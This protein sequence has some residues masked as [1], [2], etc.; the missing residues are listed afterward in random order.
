VAKHSNPDDVIDREKSG[1]TSSGAPSSSFGRREFVKLIGTGS[2]VVGASVLGTE[3]IL[4][5]PQPKTQEPPDA[6]TTSLV[7]PGPVKMTLQ[8]N[9]KPHV[10]VAEPRTTLLDVLRDYIHYTGAKKVCDRGVCGACTV[11][12]NR[13]AMYSCT[14]LAIDVAQR[15]GQ[16]V[17]EIQ[18]IEGIHGEGE[19][20]PV[21]A[22]FVEN[23]AQQCGF[24]TAGFVMASKA[25]LDHH[26]KPTY[27]EVKAALG[28]NL[29]RCG[30]YMGIRHAVVEA[31]TKLAG[32]KA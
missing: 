32:G 23:D 12:V 21:S 3:A 11:I 2:V 30:T 24:C 13:H 7:G 31:G 22:A 5:E 25:H 16:P 17:A 8:I 14:V 28:G 27:D 9:G 29:C 20:H 6:A 19:L 26:P 4:A 15:P 18:T 1:D 10:V